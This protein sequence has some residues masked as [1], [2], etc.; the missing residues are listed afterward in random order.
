MYSESKCTVF[1]SGFTGGIKSTRPAVFLFHAETFLFKVEQRLFL[2]NWIMT[3]TGTDRMQR[4][5]SP[6]ASL[7]I[8]FVHTERI[9]KPFPLVTQPVLCHC[10]VLVFAQ[11]WTQRGGFLKDTHCPLLSNT[12]HAHSLPSVPALIL[13][14]IK[15]GGGRVGDGGR[16]RESS[17]ISVHLATDE[18]VAFRLRC[19]VDLSDIS[20][21]VRQGSY[22][23]GITY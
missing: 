5:M 15:D 17:G 4:L 10:P 1:K 21:R 19:W 23:G 9:N 7:Y 12:Q 14:H 22:V 3:E 20:G 8:K 11:A 13:V 18:N 6:V 2:K 16:V